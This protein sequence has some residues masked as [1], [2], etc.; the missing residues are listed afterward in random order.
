MATSLGPEECYNP[1]T[2]TFDLACRVCEGIFPRRAFIVRNCE[3]LSSLCARC[4]RRARTADAV[5]VSCRACGA[6]IGERCVTS[7]GLMRSVVKSH[8]VR[9]SDAAL[10]S[11]AEVETV[12]R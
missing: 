6:A 3:E 5:L 10:W 12:K 7:G 11:S 9:V 1:D 8:K 2:N 4:L